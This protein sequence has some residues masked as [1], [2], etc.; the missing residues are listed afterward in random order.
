M[1][2]SASLL[3]SLLVAAAEGA[4]AQPDDKTITVWPSVVVWLRI[5]VTS[6]PDPQVREWAL[7][8]LTEVKE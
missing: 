8:E 6:N 1:D 5:Q 7:R 2:I 4:A 3:C